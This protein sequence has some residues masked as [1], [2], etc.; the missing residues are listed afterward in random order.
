MSELDAPT[1]TRRARRCRGRKC[2]PNV[3]EP[4]RTDETLRTDETCPRR[5]GGIQRDGWDVRESFG[6]GSVTGWSVFRLSE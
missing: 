3:A 2:V 1:D 6:Q 4:G 5:S